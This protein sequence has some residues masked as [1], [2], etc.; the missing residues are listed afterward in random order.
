MTEVRSFR[1]SSTLDADGL[2]L[3]LAPALTPSGITAYPSFFHGFAT[4]PQVL[5][6]GLVTLADVTATRYF[7][8]TP[9]SQRDPVLT[10]QGDRLRA[11]CFSACNGVYARL[12]LLATG[13]DG[14]EIGHGTTN[15]D[16]G[17]D[18]RRALT[19]MRR[20]D[21]VHLDVGHEGMRVATLDTHAVERPVDMLSLIHI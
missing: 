19:A 2:A 16:I 9:T 4:H 8:Y 7:Q 21:L 12:D 6:R 11:E 18:M 15:V 13:F 20:T 3:A 1:S 10:A 14:G 17:A 5:A